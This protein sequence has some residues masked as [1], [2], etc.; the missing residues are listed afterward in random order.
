[1]N[2]EPSK[3]PASVVQVS[4]SRGGLPKRAIAEAD[5]T[6]KGVAGDAWANP[7]IHGGP[8]QALL[9]ISAE[10]TDE[11]IGQ[12]FA[13]FHGALGENLTTRGLDRRAWRAGQRYRAG[14][15]VIELTKPRWP[16]GALN[17]YGTGILA[18]LYDTQVQANDASSPRW[19][20]SGFYALVVQPGRVRAGDPI[21]LLA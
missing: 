9:V 5:V 20:L 4:V 3:I 2:P 12:G 10:G 11:L 8:G 7:L 6:A 16:C 14:A 1:M 13:L 19:G 21:A 15:A 18:A 17:V